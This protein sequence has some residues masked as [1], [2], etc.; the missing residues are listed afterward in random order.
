MPWRLTFSGAPSLTSI[1]RVMTS[2]AMLLARRGGSRRSHSEPWRWAR[3]QGAASRR[4]RL[5][6]HNST[7]AISP[8]TYRCRALTW[9][10]D[11]SR[12]AVLVRQ[13]LLA[14]RA[15]RNRGRPRDGARSGAAR[16]GTSWTRRWH[17]R[18][19]AWRR[20]GTAASVVEVAQVIKEPRIC[21]DIAALV[22]RCCTNSHRRAGERHIEQRQDYH[23]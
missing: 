4:L 22:R 20:K 10:S 15:G 13:P 2:R 16:G 5:L 21:A 23:A 19:C 14:A 18:W 12:V 17:R 8:K 1:L 11:S 7:I 9:A 3:R 6:R